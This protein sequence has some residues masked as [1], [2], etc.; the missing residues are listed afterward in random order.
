MLVLRWRV[1]Y[2]FRPLS[3]AILFPTSEDDIQKIVSAYVMLQHSKGPEI[4]IRC[5]GQPGHRHLLSQKVLAT[6]VTVTGLQSRT[7]LQ[8]RG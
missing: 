6:E 5:N 2:Y 4:H 3:Y 7:L 8:C 1:G